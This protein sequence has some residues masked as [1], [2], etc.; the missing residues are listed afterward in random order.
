MPRIALDAAVWMRGASTSDTISDGGFSP[1]DKGM[2]LSAT[3]GILKQGATGAGAATQFQSRGIIG[4]TLTRAFSSPGAALA[5]SANAS[6]DGYVYNLHPTSAESNSIKYGPDIGRAYTSTQSDICFY[7]GKTYYT[8]TTNIAEDGDFDWWTTVRAHAPLDSTKRHTLF[9]HGDILY[10]TDGNVLHSWDGTTSALAVFDIPTDMMITAAVSHKGYIYLAATGWND[11]MSALF[12][13]GMIYIWDAVSATWVDDFV[14][15][16]L[17]NVLFSYEGILYAN[18]SNSFGF[19]NG[20]VFVKIRQVNIFFKHQITTNRGRILI[21][22]DNGILA[23]GNPVSG[24]QRFVFFPWTAD[25]TADVNGIVSYFS[26]NIN[27]SI[28]TTAYVISLDTPSAASVRYFKFNKIPL[29]DY[30]YIRK[31]I[32][33]MEAPVA[34][35]DDIRFTY[36]DGTGT[37]VTVGTVNNTDH[38]GLKEITFD[39]GDNPATFT[40]QPRLSI[41][42]GTNGVMRLFIDYEYSEGRTNK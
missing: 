27:A 10:V 31:F 6:N 33:T 12:G 1:D 3:V 20:D 39:L 22:Q 21:A 19:F 5:L 42:G 24:R 23:Y 30:S 32:V 37:T 29:G 26:Q 8:S 18:K 41:N 15:D 7:K 28:G 4:S 17:V 2:N 13:K 25:S 34:P 9:V 16:E 14:I 40:V 11:L 36:I 35:G 38:N